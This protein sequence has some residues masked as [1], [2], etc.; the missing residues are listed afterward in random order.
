MP[1][2]DGRGYMSNALN[3]LMDP[4]LPVFAITVIGFALG[5]SGRLSTGD[6]R[7]INRFAMTVLVP[8]LLFRIVTGAP[9]EQ[10]SFL[11]VLMYALVQ[12]FVFAGGF[13]LATRIFQRGARESVLL[14]FSGIFANNAFYVLPI[15]IFVYGES[16]V[17]PVTA[18][19][20]LDATISFAL[21]TMALQ[22]M[23]VGAISPGAVMRSIGGSPILLSLIA[24]LA[25][26]ALGLSVPKSV[27]T[28]LNFNGNAA[29]PVGLFA[30]GVVLSSTTFRAETVVVAFSAIKLV[31]FPALIWGALA[32]FVPSAGDKSQF[33][34]AAAGP[35]GAMGFSLA[36]LH[37]V[38]TDAIAQVVV[39]TSILTLLSLSLLA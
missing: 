31:L 32:I 27:E 12:A 2:S 35:A 26:V 7:V 10:F 24:G 11:P 23:N 36:L 16:G 37:G 38:R 33:V 30:L 4:I 1:L 34:L 13:I 25:F 29:A 21:V 14:A 39:W 17:L 3:V 28:F 5:R 8:I 22:I 19:I 15:S 18:I 6:A 9:L 20:A